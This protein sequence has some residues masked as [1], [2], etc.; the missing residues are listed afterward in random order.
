VPGP[1]SRR[2]EPLGT[3]WGPHVLHGGVQP[4]RRPLALTALAPQLTTAY[5]YSHVLGVKGSQ[6]QILSSR[7]DRSRSGGVSEIH[8]EPLLDLREPNGEPVGVQI[9]RRWFAAGLVWVVLRILFMAV[10]ALVSA[11]RISWR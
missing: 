9:T 7:L 1:L 6:V 4:A 2:S 11:G 8:P 10:A 3:T 5:A